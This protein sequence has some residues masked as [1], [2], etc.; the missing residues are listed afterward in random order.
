MALLWYE[1][2]LPGRGALT[3][4]NQA[5]TRR[6]APPLGEFQP[7]SP[8]VDVRAGRWSAAATMAVVVAVDLIYGKEASLVVALVFG[9]FVAC[10]LTTVR[11]TAAAAVVATLFGLALGW[12]DGTVGTSAHL[13]RVAAVA[14]GGSLAVWL[15][16]Q[17]SRRE[18]K[19]VALTRVA[20]AA[21]QTILHPLPAD[22]DGVRVTA[23]YVSAAAE[24]RV[25]GDFYDATST[26]WGMRLMVGDVRGK[27]LDAVRL[28]SVLLGEF[29]SRVASE[30]DLP[31]L[32]GL[33]DGAG[34]RH[35]DASGEDFATAVFVQLKGGRLTTVRCG[36]PLP[37]QFS[38]GIVQPVMT[39]VSLPLCMGGTPVAGTQVVPAGARLLFYSDGA[40]EGRDR[41]GRQFD[42]AASLARHG[43]SPA[44]G[45]VLD[46]ILKDLRHHCAKGI[47]DD[48]VLV[49][50]EETGPIGRR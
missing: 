38:A 22:I 50:V 40:F 43:A 49:L 48:V 45:D 9:P 39:A 7:A 16:M 36:H 27:G 28:A 3:L 29:R 26:P 15:A 42:L 37:L 2:G 17:R 32:A 4:S 24:A 41:Q 6:T 19:L 5:G 8:A 34:G 47:D 46:L 11:D 21:Q 18:A 14:V 30:P 13:V 25:G 23:R 10:A 35:V 20:D 1:M 12:P 31:T 33:V 44:H